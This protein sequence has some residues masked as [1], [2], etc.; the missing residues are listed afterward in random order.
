MFQSGTGFAGKAHLGKRMY[1]RAL[2]TGT[3]SP[4]VTA[5]G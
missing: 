3:W 5:L 1:Q 4:P 2:E